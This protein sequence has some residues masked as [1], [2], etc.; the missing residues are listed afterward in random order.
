[1]RRLTTPLC[2]IAL[3]F[4][5]LTLPVSGQTSPTVAVKKAK[6]T[7]PNSVTAL[8]SSLV[9]K[10]TF[11]CAGKFDTAGGTVRYWSTGD[12]PTTTD[13][14]EALPGETLEINGIDGITNIHFIR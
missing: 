3:A 11:Y 13:G 12:S 6:V 4:A 10:N 5:V 2:T 7:I 1:M 8:P 14:L 9:T